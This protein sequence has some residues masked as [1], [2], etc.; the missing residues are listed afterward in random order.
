[1]A[2]IDE[3]LVEGQRY[4]AEL[5][6]YFS[7][8]YR[9][10]ATNG[11]VGRWLQQHGI[12]RIF[13]AKNHE[14]WRWS[15][16]Y[17]ADKRAADTGNA[18]IETKSVDTQDKSGWAYTSTAQL[19]MYYIP[20]SGVIYVVAMTDLRQKLPQWVRSYP[21]RACLNQDPRTGRQYRTLGRIV[22]LDA[23]GDVCRKQILIHRATE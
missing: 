14:K 1:V 13:V 9:I 17:K 20:P 19:L 21:E 12:D 5:D 6:E 11:Q 18:F 7:R 23:F 4:E 2:W 22:P 3:Q 10:E 8:W 16:E 15:V